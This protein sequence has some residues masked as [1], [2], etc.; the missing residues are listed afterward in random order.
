MCGEE[1]RAVCPASL[2][3]GKV[4]ESLGTLWDTLAV[5]IQNVWGGKTDRLPCFLE[6]WE[7]LGRL[8]N[9]PANRVPRL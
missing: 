8:W 6:I 9:A 7:N 2:N 1:K 5:S 4:C 3:S